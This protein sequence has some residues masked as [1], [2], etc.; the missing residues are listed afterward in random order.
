MYVCVL[1]WINIEAMKDFQLM[2]ASL[3]NGRSLQPSCVLVF[4]PCGDPSTSGLLCVDNGTQWKEQE[5]TSE[6]WFQKSMASILGSLPWN[7]DFKESQIP[8]H[9]DTQATYE[10]T[11]VLR[12]W[13]LRPIAH[14]EWSLPKSHKWAWNQLSS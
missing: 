7:T 8:Y 6:G 9:E 14:E 4:T 2:V 10:E 5:A 11:H 13:H 12:N 1:R 3:Q